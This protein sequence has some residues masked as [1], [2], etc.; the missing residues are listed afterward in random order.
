MREPLHKLVLPFGLVLAAV[1]FVFWT[2]LG[3]LRFDAWSP[4]GLFRAVFVLGAV[5]LLAGVLRLAQWLTGPGD[6]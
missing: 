4:E 2:V 3:Y 5:G 6:S 1:T